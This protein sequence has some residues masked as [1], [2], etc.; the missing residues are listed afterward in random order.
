[1]AGQRHRNNSIWPAFHAATVLQPLERWRHAE[2]RSPVLESQFRGTRDFGWGKPVFQ[3]ECL[4]PAAPRNL[5]QRRTKY[6]GSLRTGVNRHRCREEILALGAAE[7][8]IPRGDF[9]FVQSHQLQFAESG[10]VRSPDRGT[11]ANSWRDHLDGDEFTTSA[12]RP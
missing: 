12:V 7:F 4:H 10:R 6:P 11:I 5:R 2:P 3:S 8:A 9:Q 1:M